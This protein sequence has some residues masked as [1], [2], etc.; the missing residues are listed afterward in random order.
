MYKLETENIQDFMDEITFLQQ[1]IEILTE[2][3]RNGDSP[4]EE[5]GDL[6]NYVM[7]AIYQFSYRKKKEIQIIET[8]YDMN[9]LT[10]NI[11]RWA[12]ERG[13][14][15]GDPTK[16]MLKLFEEVGELAE[17]LAKGREEDILDG[18]GD[19][20]VVLTI[21]AMQNGTNIESCVYKAYQEIKDRK[22]KMK[23][24]VFV[25]ESDL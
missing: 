23:N 13:L 21:L 1:M 15:D 11:E 14:D 18:I 19:A 12:I 25:K 5:E 24:G 9:A 3:E 20:F 2:V 6:T 7:Q 4:F 17:G 8:I 22:G 16:Q 10:T